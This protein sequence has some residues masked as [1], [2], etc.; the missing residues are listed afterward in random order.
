MPAASVSVANR[1]GI[2]A[3][4]GAI[5]AALVAVPT[6]QCCSPWCCWCCSGQ[7]N[8]CRGCWRCSHKCIRCCCCWRPDNRVAA[9]AVA[10]GPRSATPV[11]VVL[12]KHGAE[13]W[14]LGQ[15]VVPLMGQG[16]QVLHEAGMQHAHTGSLVQRDGGGLQPAG[17]QQQEHRI[18]IQHQS[19]AERVSLPAAP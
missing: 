15:D 13:V 3:V 1:A 16:Q 8:L 18:P 9:V 4:A 14:P 19:A 12:A 17:R 7:Y 10:L 11:V 2:A 6:Q 5:R